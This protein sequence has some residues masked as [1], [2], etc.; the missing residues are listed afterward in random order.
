METTRGWYEKTVLRAV[1]CLIGLYSVA[2]GLFALLPEG[3]RTGGVSWRGK[4]GVSFSDAPGAVR[5]WLW[6]EA[7]LPQAGARREFEKLPP[8]VRELLL[9]TLAPAA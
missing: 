9:T 1:P 5:R 7:V 8:S 6:A 4:E 2:A 3:K